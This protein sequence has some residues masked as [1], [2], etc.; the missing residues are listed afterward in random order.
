[1]M[2]RKSGHEVVRKFLAVSIAMSLLERISFRF[3]VFV[4]SSAAL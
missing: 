1:M 3:L 4:A 2:V